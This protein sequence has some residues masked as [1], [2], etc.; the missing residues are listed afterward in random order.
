MAAPPCFDHDTAQ[1]VNGGIAAGL[2]LV[3]MEDWR[4][5]E[6]EAPNDK[7]EAKRLPRLL[8]LTFRKAE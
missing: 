4:D 7:K 8:A 6:K 1:F 3:K 5:E 2:S